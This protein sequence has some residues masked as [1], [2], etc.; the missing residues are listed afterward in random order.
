MRKHTKWHMSSTACLRIM[1]PK[2]YAVCLCCPME[3]FMMQIRRGKKRNVFLSVIL[4]DH[5]GWEINYYQWCNQMYIKNCVILYICMGVS[6]LILKRKKRE[7]VIAGTKI[8]SIHI[9]VR[10]KLERRKM[11]CDWVIYSLNLDSFS[12]LL[13]PFQRIKLNSLYFK[14]ASNLF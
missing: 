12:L 4:I 14:C 11:P 5:P 9:Y 1:A 10:G 3:V 7:I 13:V 6:L 2:L 8:R